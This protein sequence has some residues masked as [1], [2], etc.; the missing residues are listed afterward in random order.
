MINWLKRKFK[1]MNSVSPGGSRIYKYEGGEFSKTK[2]GISGEESFEFAKIR[3]QHYDLC[4][5]ECESV[6]HEVIPMIPHIDVLA[7]KPNSDRPFWT[8]I[9]SGMSNLP[10]TMPSDISQNYSRAELVFYTQSPE[11]IYLDMLRTLAHF[12]HDNE[13][14]L[15]SGHTMPNG[16]PPEF[17][18]ENSPELNTFL[19]LEPLL[20]SDRNIDIK[21]ESNQLQLLWVLPISNAEC[22]FKLEKGTDS[23]LD[24]LEENNHPFVFEENRKSYI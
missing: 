6:Y 2:I 20:S 1:L 16:N 22:N 10:M 23:F 12:P 17:I 24:I 7:Y 4:F 14:W 18:F 15:A 21:I 13:T 5:G 9:T 11:K 19:F 8:L 3:E